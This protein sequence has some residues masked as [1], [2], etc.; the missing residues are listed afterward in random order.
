MVDDILKQWMEERRVVLLT[1][2]EPRKASGKFGESLNIQSEPNRAVMLGDS[3]VW[4]MVN[5]RQ[6]NK[7]QSPEAIRNFV[8]FAGS[9]FLADWVQQKGLSISPYA[10][11]Y[12]IARNGITVPNAHNDGRLLDDTFTDESVQDLQRRLTNNFVTQITSDIKKI[13]QQ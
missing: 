5:G 8:G 11:A 10:V 7:D 6:P 13:W 12:H 9:T 1:N 3:H 2:Y 4:Y